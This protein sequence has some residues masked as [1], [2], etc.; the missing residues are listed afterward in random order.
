M[1]R[2]AIRRI[3]SMPGLYPLLAFLTAQRVRV[4]G[5]SMAPTLVPGERVLCDRLAYDVGA[6][7]LG[8][9]VL[10]RHSLRPGMRLI[11]RVA[12]VPGDRVTTMDGGRVLTRDEFWL[13]GDAP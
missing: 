13:L 6:P 2:K 3:A 10:A 8:D 4:R 5:W 11:K 1:N 9:I 7:R 12:A